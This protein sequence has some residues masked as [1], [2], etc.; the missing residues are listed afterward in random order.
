MTD[1]EAVEGAT[2][3]DGLLQV[4]LDPVEHVYVA[5]SVT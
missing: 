1:Q 5:C 4:L 2:Y 3:R